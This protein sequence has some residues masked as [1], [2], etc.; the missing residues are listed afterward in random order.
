[1]RRILLATC[2]ATC[3]PLGTA[4]AGDVRVV[5][6]VG[7]PY[8]TVQSAVDASA[9]GDVVLV[10]AGDY[11]GFNVVGKGVAVVADTGDLVRIFGAIRVRN[12]TGDVLLA[13]LQGT[14]GSGSLAA[15]VNALTAAS[16]TGAL[17]VQHC[18]L[19][20]SPTGPVCERRHAALVQDCPNVAFLS[21]TLTAAN[22][23]GALHGSGMTG[24]S[25][26]S[27]IRSSVAVHDSEL[28]GGSTACAALGY[29]GADG[30]EGLQADA[31]TFVFAAN[32]VVR[33]GSGTGVPCGDGGGGGHGVE[34]RGAGTSVRLLDTLTSGGA[35]GIGNTPYQCPCAPWWFC[36]DCFWDGYPG[37]PVYT[38]PGAS[39]VTLAGQHRRLDGPDVAREATTIVLECR[40]APGD[41]VALA[42]GRGA[43]FVHVPGAN[44]VQLAGPAGT[45][46]RYR[47][48]GMVPAG[49]VLTAPLT[50]LSLP[51]NV[52]G[53]VWH[54]Q[55]IHVTGAGTRHYAGS[56]S[57]VVLDSAF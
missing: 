37:Q 1:M 18:T 36:C 13:G 4:L 33:G 25:G 2:L 5:V 41:L 15:E 14:G 53:E 55:T 45:P 49:G 40:G 17:R 28:R 34:A 19:A 29:V 26:L 30:G 56:L 43:P 22:S 48:L 9:D 44:G 20:G 31:A 46:P 11:N 3:V 51:P 39:V 35:P 6:P 10:R 16:N 23:D 57:L 50:L 7:G 32:A 42:I 21:C 47:I 52:Q 12:C 54:L 8:L 27:A 38:Y 24:S